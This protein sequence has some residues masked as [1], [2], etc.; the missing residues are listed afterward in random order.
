MGTGTK[1]VSTFY[2]YISFKSYYCVIAVTLDL[3]LSQTH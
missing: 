1:I 3:S 2:L